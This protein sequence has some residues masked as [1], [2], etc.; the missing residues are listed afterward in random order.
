MKYVL[1]SAAALPSVIVEPDTAKAIRILDEYRRGIHDLLAPDIFPIETLNALTKAERQKRIVSGTAYP[2]WKGIM[3]D[4]PVYHAHYQLLPRAYAI[5]AA[6]M[7]AIYDCVYVALA[8]R[9]G[10]ELVTADDKLVKNLQGRFPFVI[11]LSSLP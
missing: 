2:F 4:S 7:S 5:S 11:A 3:V 8:E 10:C 6:T 9:E 1:D